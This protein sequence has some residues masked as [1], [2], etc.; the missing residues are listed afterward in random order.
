MSIGIP[1]GRKG[2]V[3]KLIIAPVIADF[4]VDFRFNALNVS[5]NSTTG[6]IV[7]IPKSFVYSRWLP[8]R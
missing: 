4:R 1:V 6:K 5:A 7:S 8:I 3:A 2:T